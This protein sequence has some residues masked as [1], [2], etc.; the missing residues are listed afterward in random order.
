MLTQKARYA[1]HAMLFLARQDGLATVVDIAAAEN[2]P[3]KFLE[4]IL[5]ALKT[6]GLVIGKR[7]PSGG[8]LLYR[9]ALGSGP[10][11]QPAGLFTLPGLQIHRNLRNPPRLAGGPGYDL[12]VA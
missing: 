5:S 3:R 7:G 11:R 10:L 12:F 1:L 2:I 8:Y 4:Q 9:R 6:N